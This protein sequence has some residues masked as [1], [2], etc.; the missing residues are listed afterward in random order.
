MTRIPIRL[1]VTLAFALVSAVVLAALGY[2][3]YAR[4]DSELSEQIDQSLRTHGDDISS[5]VAGGDL[6]RNANLLGR[7]ESFA[8][9]LTSD[10]RIYATTPQLG[11]DPQITPAEAARASR[12]SFLVT[13]PH[14]RSITGH[15]RLLARSANGP[16]GE[17]FGCTGGRQRVQTQLSI[18]R[19]TAP[20]VLILWPVVDQKEQ[21]RCRQAPH[22]T[23]E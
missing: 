5:L 23:V 9:V 16:R 21:V 8:Q 4:F 17:H 12:E 19:L 7:E 11:A 18:V 2:F 22:Q 15:A 14:V 1:R 20:A 6:A 10:G 13:R 3:V